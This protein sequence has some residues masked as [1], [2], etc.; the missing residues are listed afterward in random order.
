MP[1]TA[2]LRQNR[3]SYFRELRGQDRM[4]SIGRS[5]CGER[6]CCIKVT[7]STVF[8]TMRPNR[9]FE[10]PKS[11]N[12]RPNVSAKLGCSSVR[13][14]FPLGEA[15]DRVTGVAFCR[16]FT[17]AD[18]RPPELRRPDRPGRRGSS[19]STLRAGEAVA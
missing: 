7:V 18:E 14:R 19:K 16:L 4:S 17:L 8:K 3:L 9:W 11:A 10:S 13:V 2:K 6:Q 15:L 1:V 12:V 5:A